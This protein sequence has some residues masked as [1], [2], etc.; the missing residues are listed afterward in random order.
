M[1]DLDGPVRVLLVD[2]SAVVRGALGR[3]IDATADLR[4]ITTAVNGQQALDALRQTA[5]DVVLL[6]VEMPEMDGLTALP[7]I[8]SRFPNT[9]VI[10]A[11][12]LT[13]RGA[14]VTMQALAAG[15]SDFIS[16]PSARVGSAG[17]AALEREIVEKTRAIGR[18]VRNRQARSASV[19]LPPAADADAPRA[20]NGVSTGT[21][22]P[23]IMAEANTFNMPP[24]V[25]AVSASTGGPNALADFL[26]NL[27]RPLDVP[28]L[29]TQHM[30]AVFTALLAQRLARD[31]GHNVVEAAHNDAL[32]PGVVYIAPGGHHMLVATQEGKPFIRLTTTEPENFCRPSADPMLRSIAATYGAAVLSVVLT[33]MGD[34][35][36]R[37]CGEVKH[38]G[39]SV[40]VQ[41]EATSVVWGMP[42]AV[43][44]AGLA[45]WIMPLSDIGPKVSALVKGLH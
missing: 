1:N 5:I 31:T 8:L 34:D 12:S 9:R 16:K 21:A 11:S 28:V 29:I 38:R 35:G 45:D 10:M 42:G 13:Q 39:G 27:S 26:Q 15:A 37:G 7:L 17:L 32:Q 4:V 20:A 6:D 22:A 14:A 19:S 41:D 2:D 25:I 36:C 30:P 44:K 18:A 33:G 3:I 40:L 24:R 43:S 23:A